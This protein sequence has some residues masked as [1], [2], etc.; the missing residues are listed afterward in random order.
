MII[1]CYRQEGL[2]RP[3]QAEEILEEITDDTARL[4]KDR[5]HM[6][7]EIA[8]SRSVMRHEERTSELNLRNSLL[9]L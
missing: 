9:N 1:I 4:E 6:Y 2:I 5:N 3:D 8:K 7:R